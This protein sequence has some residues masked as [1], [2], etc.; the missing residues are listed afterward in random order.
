MDKKTKIAATVLAIAIGAGVGNHFYTKAQID[1][2]KK[3]L[4]EFGIEQEKAEYISRYFLGMKRDDTKGIKQAAYMT[5][6]E[7]DAYLEVL[8]KAIKELKIENWGAIK[9][10]EELLKKFNSAISEA[11]EE[12]RIEKI[13]K[14]Y[15]D[16]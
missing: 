10:K 12:K 15:G 7:R 3:D 9:S 5:I 1:P 6:A 4:M 11:A 2:F 13:I 8:N 14:Q 16:Q